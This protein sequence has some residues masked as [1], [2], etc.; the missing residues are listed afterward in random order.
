MSFRFKQFT[1]DDS[2]C[3][4]KVGT[5]GVLL[6]AWAMSSMLHAGQASEPARIL[7]VGTGS[8]VVALMLAQR[9][10]SASITAIDINAEAAVQAAANFASSQWT[11][12]LCSHHLS[13]QQLAELPCNGYDLIVSNPPYFTETLKAP[14]ANRATARHADSLPL[15]QLLSLSAGMLKPAGRLSI[16]TPAALAKSL[17]RLA[18]ANGLLTTALCHVFSKEGKP[19]L[20]LL[21]EF[22]L[23]S[24]SGWTPS[25]EAG[26]FAIPTE[27]TLFLQNSD[28]S[29]T[30][31]YSR[32]TCDF[33]L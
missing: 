24:A 1:V 11:E 14:D 31:D 30:A 29:R 19:E 4:M 27:S 17:R 3:A 16:I 28:G 18:A 20:R 33:Y 23:A 13:L 21:S 6:G 2:H 5:D 15:E 25:S 22:A 9:F 32:L 7:D 8:G 26:G 10:R 12:R